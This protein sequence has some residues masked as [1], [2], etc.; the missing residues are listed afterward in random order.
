MHLKIKISDDCLDN[1]NS[2]RELYEN[3]QHFHEG[4][5]G[6]DLYMPNSI[7]IPGGARGVQ[8]SLEIA[9]EAFNNKN[10]E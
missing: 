8:V 3:H 5:A 6:L 2:L 10:K 1:S 9:C 4:D 7:L